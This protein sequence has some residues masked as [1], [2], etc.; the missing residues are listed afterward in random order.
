MPIIKDPGDGG[1][2]GGGGG[3]TGIAPLGGGFTIGDVEILPGASMSI[4]LYPEQR[5]AVLNTAGQHR[6]SSITYISGTGTAGTVNTAMTLLTVVLPAD[7]LTV[8][9]DRMRI[10]TYFNATAGATIVGETDINAVPV[11][12]TTHAG[13][14]SLNLTECWL[15]YIDATH[16][17]IIEQEVGA[18]GALSAANVAGFNWAA[19]QDIIFTQTAVAA[20]AIT[21]FALIVDV[22][23]LGVE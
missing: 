15:H 22:F 8:V 20:K 21:L 17:N 4:D 7:T 2:G 6:S 1:G 19:A 23:P 5:R 16:A 10:R 9:G 11:A 3:A 14:A 13:G 12:H 18:L